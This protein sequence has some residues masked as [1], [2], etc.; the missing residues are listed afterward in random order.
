MLQKIQILQLIRK[1]C[2]SNSRYVILLVKFLPKSVLQ[3]NYD[4]KRLNYS[5]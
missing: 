3:I 5:I 4:N 1:D 2:I